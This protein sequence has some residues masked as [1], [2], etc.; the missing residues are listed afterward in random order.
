M[1]VLVAFDDECVEGLLV[2]LLC[3]LG[4]FCRRCC[5][6]LYNI[7]K[8]DERVLEVIKDSNGVSK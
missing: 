4:Y 7:V 3:W 5:F 6:T 1:V 8:H 2:S